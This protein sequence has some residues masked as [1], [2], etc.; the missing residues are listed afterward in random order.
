[1]GVLS[2]GRKTSRD[3]RK[4]GP[5]CRPGVV[6]FRCQ[7]CRVPERT[8]TRP[9]RDDLWVASFLKWRPASAL[10]P[11][12]LDPAGAASSAAAESRRSRLLPSGWPQPASTL[13]ESTMTH[14]TFLAQPQQVCRSECFAEDL[15]GG[16][17]SRPPGRDS[18]PGQLHFPFP[19]APYR[20]ARLPFDAA[21]MAP[22]PAR[23][24][25]SVQPRKIGRAHV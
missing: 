1:M 19:I 3:S 10:G 14:T 7:R 15:A 17:A 18:E 21:L 11:R 24:T 8:V 13:A 9:L 4:R 25:T 2:R 12:A 20:A 5:L 16:R 22:V 23:L 6:S